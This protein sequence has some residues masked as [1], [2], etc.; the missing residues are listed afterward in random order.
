MTELKLTLRTALILTG[1]GTAS[2][3]GGC[4]GAV[5]TEGEAGGSTQAELWSPSG[6]QYW[7]NG[8]V[9]VCFDAAFWDDAGMATWR[10]NVRK[11]VTNEIG[12][13]ANVN[14]TDFTKCTA[15][16]GQAWLKLQKATTSNSNAVNM[17]YV[18]DNKIL[19]GGDRDNQNV[20]LHEFGHKL[21]YAHEF[22][23]PDS[24]GCASTGTNTANATF[25]TKYDSE[26]IMSSTYCQSNRILSAWDRAGVTATY[27]RRAGSF[28]AS[29]SGGDTTDPT[30]TGW[31]SVAT[32]TNPGDAGLPALL[33]SDVLVGNFVNDA[34][35]SAGVRADDLLVTTGS[36]WYV[37]SGGYRPWVQVASSSIRAAELLV[38]DFNHD[39]I[40]DVLRATG[41][42]W[43]V[44][45]SANSNWTQL[46]VSA[47]PKSELLAGDF[48][49]DGT[50]DVLRVSGGKWYLST[51]GS[52]ALVQVNTS[53]ATFIDL[54]VGNFD[55]GG[56]DIFYADGTTW[57]FSSGGTG[58]WQSLG[59]SNVKGRDLLVANF[60][61]AGGDDVFATVGGNWK[62]SAEGRN[63]WQVVNSSAYTVASLKVANFGL[64]KASVFKQ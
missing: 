25:W 51:G 50:D 48:N 60:D 35:D 14:F 19:F 53:S 5:E 28:I 62:L 61:G 27:G 64:E 9:R 20:V 45:F 58:A 6:T 3:L 54:K 11:W 31:V 37:S 34:Q 23:N 40:S 22:D 49:N 33:L 38:G 29:F 8:T 10:A 1:I 24:D 21:G 4:S 26:S 16:P 13:F 56:Q 43:D 59:T 47:A 7:P 18:T 2:L 15:S 12:P 41:S 57:R 44:S 42:V 52:S 63:A 30:W 39:G 32:N 36:A 17:G 55:G 46:N